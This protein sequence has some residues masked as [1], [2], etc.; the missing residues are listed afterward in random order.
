MD[1]KSQLRNVAFGGAWSEQIEGNEILRQS[2]DLLRQSV[3]LTLEEDI[4]EREDIRHALDVVLEQHPKGVAIGE[5]W[6]KA[7]SLPLPALRRAEL[8][9]L[10]KLIEAQLSARLK[11]IG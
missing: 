5:A 2:V 9:A 8:Y 6:R 10:V 3:D 1:R 7:L 4:R 11:G